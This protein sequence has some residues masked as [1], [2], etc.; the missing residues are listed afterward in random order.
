MS[1]YRRE[2]DLLAPVSA[3]V[4][5]KGF[6]W[7]DTELAF[8]EYRIDLYGF[9]RVDAMSLAIE[10]KLKNWRRALQQTIIY[11]LCADW[12]FAA[13]P[14]S[15]VNDVVQSA[16]AEHGVGLIGVGDTGRCR[17]VLVPRQSPD[18]REWYRKHFV[19]LVCEAG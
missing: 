5:R 3:Y 15:A 6:R 18:V 14:E 12:V 2:A 17:Q 4:R 1:S 8:Y 10:L 13:L 7:Q 9:S 19:S 16:F 11:Q